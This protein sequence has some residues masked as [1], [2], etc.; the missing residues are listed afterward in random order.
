MNSL[1][2]ARA[3]LDCY[4]AIVRGPAAA[5]VLAAPAPPPPPPQIP[6]SLE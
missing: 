3:E 5:E 6:E 4:E 2:A 1:S